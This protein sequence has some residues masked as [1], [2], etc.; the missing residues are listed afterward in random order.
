[1]SLTKPFVFRLLALAGGG[2]FLF[3]SHWVGSRAARAG[4]FPAAR[5]SSSTTTPAAQAS[6][7]RPPANSRRSHGEEAK[8]RIAALIAASPGL[9]DDWETRIAIRKILAELTAEDLAEI[10]A[11]LL[12][13]DDFLVM[14]VGAAWAELDP[15]AALRAALANAHL[16]FTPKGDR[17]ALR[18]LLALFNE[19]ASDQPAIAL[20]WLQSPDL[21]PELAGFKDDLYE[22]AVYP[23]LQKDFET[24]SNAV[25]KM[26]PDGARQLLRNWGGSYSGDPVMRDQLVEFAKHTGRPQ[27]YAALNASLL[28]TWP[29]ED[30]VAM[31]NYLIDLKRYLESGAVPA[32]DGPEIDAAAVGAAIGREYDRPALE[33]WM[34]RYSGSAEVPAPLTEAFNTWMRKDPAKVDQW[35]AE[36]PPSLQVDALHAAVVPLLAKSGQL[37]KA[38]DNVAAISNPDVRQ[39]ATDRLNVIWS[40]LSP[41]AAAKWRASLPGK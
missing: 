30:S 32:T 37:S 7:A 12:P 1:M 10:F 15:A 14:M 21:P 33:W 23:M 2:V 20:A 3:G 39:Q 26:S 6:S 28:E 40:A 8:K 9:G 4:L 5:S 24:A 17:R 27:D 13:Q 31:M 35:F 11:G 18:P 41:D 29:Q 38:A 25:M 22:A 36:Q 34:E 16:E 19:W